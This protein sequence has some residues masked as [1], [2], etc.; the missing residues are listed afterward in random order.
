[1]TKANDKKKPTKRKVT[2][3][4]TSKKK[5]AKQA[6]NKP[7]RNDK[8]QYVK[9][10][11][12]NVS[13][14]PVGSVGMTSRIRKVLEKTH[15]TSGK[16]VADM[17]AEVMVREALKNPAK[18]WQFIKE[19]MDRDEGRSDKLDILNE[20]TANDTAL[21]IRNAIDEMNLGVPEHE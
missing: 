18:M 3:K 7:K 19:V 10:E 4:A 15:G 1:L 11:S 9:G 8:G 2:K 6:T 5:P 12:G 21:D 20:A 16:Q 17:L 14:R 13:G